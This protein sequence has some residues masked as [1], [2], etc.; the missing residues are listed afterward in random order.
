MLL[1]PLV[2]NAIQH[3]LE[4]KVAG[5]EVAIAARREGAHVRIDVADTGMGFAPTT[6]GG[7]GL[8]NLRDRLRLLYGEGSGL[9]I[10]ENRPAGTVVTIAL[11]A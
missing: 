2:E 11:P 3:G 1:Q 6:R 7:L 4:P 10:A 8:S 9:S 5:G